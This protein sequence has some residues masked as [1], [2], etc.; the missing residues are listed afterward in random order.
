MPLDVSLLC[1]AEVDQSWKQKLSAAPAYVP[2]PAPDYRTHLPAFPPLSK[3]LQHCG[4]SKVVQKTD[5]KTAATKRQDEV[6]FFVKRLYPPTSKRGWKRFAS[7]WFK[8]G[9]SKP[10]PF[11]DNKENKCPSSSEPKYGMYLAPSVA[12]AILQADKIEYILEIEEKKARLKVE[13][14][15][16]ASELMVKAA[17][18]EQEAEEIEEIMAALNKKAKEATGPERSSSSDWLDSEVSISSTSDEEDSSNDDM[19]KH[20]NVDDDN[21][22]SEDEAMDSLASTDDMK[23]NISAKKKCK[24]TFYGNV[25]AIRNK[26]ATKSKTAVMKY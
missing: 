22:V 6:P 26:T 13:E 15:R 20:D 5:K 3:S 9:P 12:K 14:E 16:R 10:D 24:V 11:L 17:A 8:P 19:K 25:C 7:A 23:E 4:Y 21:E 2:Q 1:P 18:E